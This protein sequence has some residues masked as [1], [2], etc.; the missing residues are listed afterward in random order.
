MVHADCT[1]VVCG[2]GATNALAGEVCDDAGESAVC[3]GDCTAVV[4]GDG[5][6]NMTAGEQCD[7]GGESAAG[8]GEEF[9][10]WSYV[11]E[12]EKQVLVIEQWGENEFAAS[13]GEVVEPYQFSNILPG[14]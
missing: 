9:I 8:S 7:D 4:C 10:N 1:L 13:A 12:S 2:D 5:N 6:H 11:D 14:G 3:D